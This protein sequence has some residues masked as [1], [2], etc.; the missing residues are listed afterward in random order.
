[1]V[2]SSRSEPPAGT[3]VLV[4]ADDRPVVRAGLATL[5][6][7]LPV[8]LELPVTGLTE[9]L[10]EHDH[11][12]VDLLV[13]GIREAGTDAFAAIAAVAQQRRSMPVLAIAD[14][15]SV[16]ELREAVIAGVDS[17]LL[18]STSA[19]ELRDAVRRTLSGDRVI[20]PS[21]AIQLA[22]AGRPSDGGGAAAL[23]RQE[24]DVLRLAADGLTNDAIAAELG[25]ASRT[26]KTRIQ[27]VLGKLEVPDRTAAVARALRLGLIS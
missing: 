13:V 25:I 27:G 20:A 23:T 15:A 12:A 18:T 8:A 6:R 26:V 16:I 11:L 3:P 7:P 14:S 9:A 1:M 21:I 10:A 24:L 4:V 22:S 5:L 17:F 2:S 19:E